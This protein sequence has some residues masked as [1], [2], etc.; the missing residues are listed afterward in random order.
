MKFSVNREKLQKALQKVGSAVGSHAMLQVLSN[1][2]LEAADNTLTLTTTDLEMRISTS[3]EAVVE[4]N[5]VSTA[6]AR[7]LTSL[8]SCF[9]GDDVFFDI[10]EKDHI[11]IKCGTSSFTLLGLPADDFPAASDFE[12]KRTVQ[13]KEKD[14][15]RMVSAIRYAVSADS[16]RIVLTGVLLSCRENMAT[17]VATD[18]KRMAM[19]EKAPES[20]EGGDGDA[21][22]PL[23]AAN[24]VRRLLEG[25]AIL[26]IKI[27]ERLCMFEAGGFVV[28]SKLIEGNYPN[29]RQVVPTTFKREITVPT[30]VFLAKIETVS[31]VLSDSSSFI[32]L[33]FGDNQLRLA[34]SSS[35]VGEGSDMVEVAYEGDAFE[36]SFN[37]VFLSEPLR[38]CDSD[39]VKLQFNDPLN[40]VA[41][42]GGEGFLYVIMPIRK[43]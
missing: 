24:E 38:N 32:I 35:E 37:P 27:G 41:I 9:V 29:Y 13:I 11:K 8:V 14:F 31:L 33:D 23:K 7:K 43:K 16:S 12:V 42:E 17:L 19:Q 18:G 2:M 30:S 28:T 36:V 20:I 3:I 22:I 1:V 26:S 21:I 40:P 4:E 34:A 6:P 5:G 10:D 15:K 39:T 25:D